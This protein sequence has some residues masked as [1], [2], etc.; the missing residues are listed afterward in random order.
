M[1]IYKEE[2]SDKLEEFLKSFTK[3]EIK[4]IQNKSFTNIDFTICKGKW[5][6][7]NKLTDPEIHFV[8]YNAKLRDAI[9]NFI[10]K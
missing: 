9:I 10:S 4:N 5:V 1:N 7:I 2:D 3:S 6:M 8:I